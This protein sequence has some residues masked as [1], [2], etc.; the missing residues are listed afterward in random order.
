MQSR[1]FRL[2]TSA[3]FVGLLS[4][5]A[6]AQNTTVPPLVRAAVDDS[7]LSTLRGNT[8]PLAVAKFDRGAAPDGPALQGYS[9]RILRNVSSAADSKHLGAATCSVN[10]PDDQIG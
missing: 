9:R 7:I 4:L 5:T 1:A 2:A 6:F 10:K 8:Y 3:V